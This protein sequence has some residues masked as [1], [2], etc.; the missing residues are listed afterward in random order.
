MWCGVRKFQFRHYLSMKS[1]IRILLADSVY[2]LYATYPPV[3]QRYPYSTWL[4][5]LTEEYPFIHFMQVA[6]HDACH[7]H[8]TKTEY[9]IGKLQLSQNG[10]FY[11]HEDIIITPDIRQL[12]DE[13][14]IYGLNNDGVGILALHKLSDLESSAISVV[15]NDWSRSL[16]NQEDILCINSDKNLRHPRDIW[17]G[18]DAFSELARWIYYGEPS[19]IYPTYSEETMAPNIAHVVW[20]GGGA[21]D[22]LFYM[23]VM[24]MLHVGHVDRVYIHG[25]APNGPY[26]DRIKDNPKITVV[27]RSQYISVYGTLV[28]PREHKSDVV[29]VDILSKYGGVYMD[30]DA[31]MTRPMDTRI[32]A[33]DAVIGVC[34]GSDP[35]FPLHLMNGVMVGKQGAPFW[36]KYMESMRHYNDRSWVWNSLVKPY[37]IKERFPKSVFIDPHMQL[38]CWDKKCKPSSWYR[39]PDQKPSSIN[40]PG[41]PDWWQDVYFYHWTGTHVYMTRPHV[42]AL[43]LLKPNH[44]SV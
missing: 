8:K 28:E 27:Y 16:I 24:S 33:F 40:L 4:D 37:K 42:N 18:E 41:I 34:T 13:K 6:E 14:A 31:I 15:C 35:A 21:M 19:P 30:K 12:V 43:L 2:F 22:F 32:R 5:D 20:L 36:T 1:A 25:E 39:S 17:E 44:I 10:G 9:V 7:N 26:W 23:S 11:L 29:R 3:E 38:V